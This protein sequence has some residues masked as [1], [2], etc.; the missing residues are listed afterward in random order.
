LIS[1]EHFDLAEH[2]NFLTQSIEG[3]YRN[4]IY[5]GVDYVVR[6][7]QNLEDNY[8]LSICTY[9]LSL[10]RNAY[11]DEAFRL[12]DSRATF[13]DGKKWW[14]KPV[15]KDDK[16][17][18]YSLSR[19]ADVEMTSYALLTYLR[20]DQLSDATSIMKWLVKQRN[21]EGGFSSTQV[22]RTVK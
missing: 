20:R 2:F 21:V 14:S 3:R 7:M 16:N 1:R 5:K 11:E 19:S 17:P 4:V 10:A 6:N 15:P 9:V 8:A 13:E 18:W 22:S 12:L